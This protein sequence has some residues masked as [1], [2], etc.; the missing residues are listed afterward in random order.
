LRLEGNIEKDF[1]YATLLSTD[2][3]PFGYLDFRLVVLPIV[4]SGKH[5]EV[6][7]AAEARNQGFLNLANWLERAQSEW[8]VRRGEKAERM[9][10][11]E[12]LD[13][14]RK[15]S[16]QRKAQYKVL[17]PTSATYLCACVVE[18]KPVRFEVEGQ[19]I[20]AQ[21]FVAESK[22]YYFD[23]DN[24]EEA[25]YLTAVLNS[26]TID[27]P[28]KDMQSRGLWGPRDIH[29]KVLEFP[30]P[31]YN[32]PD[33]N[34]RALSQLGDQCSKKVEQLLPQLTKSRSIGHTRRLIKAELKEELEQ[35]DK[36]VRILLEAK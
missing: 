29:K 33:A 28:L 10:V 26:R 34:H 23:T 22:V 30:I 12:W 32:P 6:L 17:Y 36:L 13:Y 3:V 31:Q 5:F 35:I 25:Y 11:Q 24:K 16:S 18:S 21:D 20:E 1:L 7:N 14:R 15:L 9:D 4:P 2:L 27:A 19:S 8:E